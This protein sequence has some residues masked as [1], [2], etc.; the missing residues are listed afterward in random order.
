MISKSSCINASTKPPPSAHHQNMRASH[1]RPSTSKEEPE[2]DPKGLPKH[3]WQTMKNPKSNKNSPQ[4]ATA[5]PPTKTYNRFEILAKVPPDS[6]SE[7]QS[8]PQQQHNPPPIF[9]HGVT[10]Y[11]QM[12][13]S[14]SEVEEDEQYYTKS[15]ANN[16]IKLNCSTPD[17]YHN[18]VKHFRD[19]GIFSTHIN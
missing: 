10:D 4:P 17:T 19:K 8:L 12:T 6:V 11:N 3:D 18:I 14:I 9:I 15:M 2:P 1:H 5:A 16:V 7:S 13:K